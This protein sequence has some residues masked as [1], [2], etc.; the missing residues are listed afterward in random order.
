LMP[1]DGLCGTL[2]VGED[3]KRRGCG[4]REWSIDLVSVEAGS[5]ELDEQRSKKKEQIP[6]N[7]LS[8]ISGRQK[9][10]E[11]MRNIHFELSLARST[12]EF[13]NSD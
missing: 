12:I 4:W 2:L 1:I 7:G 13:V 5:N 9:E 3:W 6:S 11:T 10:R 8:D